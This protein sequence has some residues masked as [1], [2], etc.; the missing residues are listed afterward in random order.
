MPLVPNS[1]TPKFKSHRH[2]YTCEEGIYRNICDSKYIRIFLLAF[3]NS[4]CADMLLYVYTY[5]HKYT[6]KTG[7]NPEIR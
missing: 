4:M 2:S 5:A 3:A 7:N 1:S 6:P